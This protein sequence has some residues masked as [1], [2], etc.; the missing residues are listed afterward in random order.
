MVPL[1]E[2]PLPCGISNDPFHHDHHAT[3]NRTRDHDDDDAA[4]MC[5]PMPIQ[6][7]PKFTCPVEFVES[8][9]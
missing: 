7:S 2:T 8:R 1:N 5:I 3:E 4:A 6:M 9:H